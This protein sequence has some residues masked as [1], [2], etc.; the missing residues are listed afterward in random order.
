VAAAVEGAE[1][2]LAAAVAGERVPRLDLHRGQ[3]HDLRLVRLRAL[4]R[5]QRRLN[6]PRVRSR[7][8]R[9]F[10]RRVRAAGVELRNQAA[11]RDPAEL[12]RADPQ[13]CPPRAPAPAQGR[14]GQQL[15]QGRVRAP[16][17][18]LTSATPAR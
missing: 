17:P 2:A 15:C 16:A 6:L 13:R 5:D 12:R 9:T 1:A 11:R 3:R 14:A 7:V 10:P 18:S 4:R 8:P